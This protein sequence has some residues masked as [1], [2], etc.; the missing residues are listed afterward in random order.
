MYNARVT[1][2]DADGHAEKR[3][4]TKES[5]F[6]DVLRGEFGLNMSDQQI[7]ECRGYEGKRDGR[8]S[9]SFFA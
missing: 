3:W 2:R 5:E 7:D 4:L 1:I 9:A 8:R 6:R